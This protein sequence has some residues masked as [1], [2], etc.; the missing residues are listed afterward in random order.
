MEQQQGAGSTACY[1]CERTA[2]RM[3]ATPAVTEGAG[4][5]VVA[6]RPAGGGRAAGQQQL[7]GKEEV[8]MLS[9]VS[10]KI[11]KS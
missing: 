1:I 9:F 5:E 6:T 2:A 4:Q 7:M 8:K 3:A 10:F 11:S